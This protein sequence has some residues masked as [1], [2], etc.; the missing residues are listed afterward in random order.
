MRRLEQTSAQ[1]NRFRSVSEN[2]GLMIRETRSEMI[3]LK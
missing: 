1:I 2:K 3:P